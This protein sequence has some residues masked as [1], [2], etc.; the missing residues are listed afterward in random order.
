MRSRGRL[1]FFLVAISLVSAVSFAETRPS[2]PIQLH[3]P[4]EDSTWERYTEEDGITIF[5]REK[6]GSDI[7][8]AIG[9]GTIDA[10]PCRVFQVI[11]D[12]DHLVEF[13]PYLEAR[14]IKHATAD[15]EYVCEYLDFP[16]PIWDRFVHLR[17]AEVRNYHEN[18]CEYLKHWHKD[19]TYACT[20]GELEEAYEDANPH[21]IVP[22]AIEG[23]WHLLPQD[24]GG[25]TLAYYYAFTDPGGK[26]PS[27]VN[28]SF[29]DY[30]ILEL[31]RAVRERVSKSD[32][33]PPCHC[34]PRAGR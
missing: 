10:P 31:F 20:V 3:T 34:G 29:V 9:K 14:I 18:Q 1:G 13:M 6:E 30:A 8:E 23:Y 21:A 15:A 5:L 25:K 22:P 2:P 28:N 4:D 33:Y 12:S 24:G 11:T 19:E 17:I 32:L 7:K 27:W 16:W 26:I